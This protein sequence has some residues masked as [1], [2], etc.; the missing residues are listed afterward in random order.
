MWDE[1]EGFFY[2]LNAKTGERI[3]V[4]TLAGAM[5][6]WAG[7]ATEDQARRLVHDH[8]FNAAEF[9]SPYPFP[10]LAKSEVGYVPVGLSTDVMAQNTCSWRANTWIPTNY[11]IFQ[12]LRRYGYGELAELT[13]HATV[14]L[15]R[16]AGNREYY[17]SESGRGCGLDPFWGWSP[18]GWFMPFEHAHDL[19]P[20]AIPQGRQSARDRSTPPSQ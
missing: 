15:L 3:K 7:V 4:K 12:G 8:L 20:T 19:N 5:P 10:A 16:K 1:K 13:A 2:D 11:M 18:L 6:L 9:W 14:R 17:T